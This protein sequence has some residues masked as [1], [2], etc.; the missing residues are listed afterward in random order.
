[1]T[2]KSTLISISLV[3]FACGAPHAQAAS[4]IVIENMDPSGSGFNDPASPPATAGCQIGE[5]LG[6]CRLRVFS[7]AA[8]QWGALLDSNVTITVAASMEPLSCD[9]N[10]AILGSAGPTATFTN[11]PKAPRSDTAYV[12]ALANALSGAQL[13]PGGADLKARFNVN[14]DSGCL[15][16][17]SGWWYETDPLVPVPAERIAL[18]PVVFHEIAHGLGF[19][20]LYNLSTG[21]AYP[22]GYTPVWGHYLYDTSSN[23]LWKDMTNNQRKSSAIN[24]PNLIWT[25]PHTSDE[26]PDHLHKPVA[27]IIHTPS[28][29]AGAVDASEAS[30][31]PSVRTATVT[32]DVVLAV[33]QIPNSHQACGPLVNAAQAAGKIVMIRRGVCSFPEK[34][35]NAQNAGALGVIISNNQA[36]II[37]PGGSDP[38]ITIPTLSVRQ[39]TGAN[40]EAQLAIGVNATLGVNTAADYQ[41]ANSGCMRMFAP[42]VLQPGSS[43]SHFHSDASPDLLMEPALNDSLFNTVDLTLPL[44]R[45]IGWNL[46]SLLS[47]GFEDEGMLP[48][49]TAGEVPCQF[50]QP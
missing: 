10:G 25:G 9:S 15:G 41:G 11:F 13:N 47:D 44:F 3:I 45:D 29:I 31:G 33:D 18:L 12:A 38:T 26:L 35:K 50:V 2:A 39:V 24:D 40:I 46:S 28:A 49:I 8:Q 16:T 1:M 43:V 5:T 48:R 27:V 32:A 37:L 20:S 21:A 6:E 23:T 42:G 22:A 17:Y 19:T 36:G 30:F 7:V 14:I 34:V 4:T